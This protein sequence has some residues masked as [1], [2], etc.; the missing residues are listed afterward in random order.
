MGIVI[1]ARILF[2]ALLA[3]FAA[4]GAAGATVIPVSLTVAGDIPLGQDWSV[5]RSGGFSN[6]P[7]TITND[8]GSEPREITVSLSDG[9]TDVFA[10][11]FNFSGLASAIT[12]GCIGQI[13]ITPV[14]ITQGALNV[15]G[16]VDVFWQNGTTELLYSITDI[17]F[18]DVYDP[19]LFAYDLNGEQYRL[20][21]IPASEIPLP[22]ALPLFI[23]GLGSLVLARRRKR[24]S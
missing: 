11:T 9:S 13:E 12:G 5:S 17:R 14:G 21:S 23:A 15:I 10:Y 18:P 20:S 22:A 2:F 19:T 8:L 24:V 3:N 1:Q 7:C 6:F 4:A 16:S